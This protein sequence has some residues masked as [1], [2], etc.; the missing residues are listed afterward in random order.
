MS[1]RGSAW[2]WERDLLRTAHPVFLV[3][4]EQGEERGLSWFLDSPHIV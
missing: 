2:F 3:L 4:R 1:P